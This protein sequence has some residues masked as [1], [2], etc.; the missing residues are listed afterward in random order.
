LV[1]INFERV[2]YWL[3]RGA[4]TSYPIAE[5]LGKDQEA[6]SLQAVACIFKS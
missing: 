6:A 3:G 1:A 2:R 4:A 5:L